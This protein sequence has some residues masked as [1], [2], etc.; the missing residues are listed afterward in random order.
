M[1]GGRGWGWGLR[2][3]HAATIALGK[4]KGPVFVPSRLVLAWPGLPSFFSSRHLPC[5]KRLKAFAQLVARPVLA[6]RHYRRLP[7]AVLPDWRSHGEH[8]K[9]RSRC[10]STKTD[11]EPGNNDCN[12]ADTCLDRRLR[13]AVFS[14]ADRPACDRGAL[15][16][17]SLYT[18]DHPVDHFATVIH[19]RFSDTLLFIRSSPFA[20]RCR[21]RTTRTRHQRYSS[22]SAFF[23]LAFPVSS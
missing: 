13:H 14:F 4:R 7:D 9:K 16:I 10:T 1:V 5:P 17:Y 15:Y 21:Y 18:A 20:V 3:T 11:G 6:A 19:G 12:T 8:R 22:R 2:S 23:S